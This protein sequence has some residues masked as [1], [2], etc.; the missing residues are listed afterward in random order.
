[1]TQ[2]LSSDT[3]YLKSFRHTLHQISPYRIFPIINIH[4]D[5]RANAYIVNKWF[6]IENVP[7][8]TNTKGL[9]QI[10]GT[11]AK[12]DG[13]SE[14]KVLL[15]SLNVTLKMLH[16]VTILRLSQISFLIFDI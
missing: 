16:I 12:L 10:V 1:M 2:K 15:G 3:K 7:E 13:F 6:M 8:P 11:F 9:C 14:S 4:I 5:F